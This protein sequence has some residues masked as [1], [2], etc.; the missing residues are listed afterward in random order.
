MLALLT[1]T[2]G[3]GTEA[4][5]SEDALPEANCCYRREALLEVGGFPASVGRSGNRLLSGDQVVDLVMA[6]RGWKLFFDPAIVI[7]HTIHADRLTPGWIRRRWFWQGVSDYAGRMYLK[8]KG[9]AID[10]A[11]SLE[12]PLGIADWSFINDDKTPPTE[13]GLKKLHALGLV[14]AM[15][16]LVPVEI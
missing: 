16:G 1:A 6:L 13:E 5:Y 11:L 2:S 12:L 3:C 15:S 10:Y 7:H 9:V 8:S 14:L 4:R